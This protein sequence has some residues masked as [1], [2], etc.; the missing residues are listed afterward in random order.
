MHLP[1]FQVF[2]SYWKSLLKKKK[3][4]KKYS[5]YSCTNRTKLQNC[6]S[7]LDISCQSASYSLDLSQCKLSCGY[8]IYNF[9]SLR[10]IYN[11]VIPDFF[12]F[13]LLLF[14]RHSVLCWNKICYPVHYKCWKDFFF[15]RS[16]LFFHFNQMQM[17]YISHLLHQ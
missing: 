4:I 14:R 1:F 3:R 8:C 13:S 12:F 10:L 15:E 7:K 11:T 17:L 9:K 16:L 6:T 5:N 2:F